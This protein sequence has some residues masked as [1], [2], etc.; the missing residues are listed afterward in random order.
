[1]KRCVFSS[2]LTILIGWFVLLLVIIEYFG[3]YTL[4][5]VF[6]FNKSDTCFTSI[7][8]WP[9]GSSFHFL[10]ISLEEQMFLI[11]IA[12]THFFLLW[13]VL[14]VLYLRNSY[15]TQD[16]KDFLLFSS[17]V[18]GVLGFTFKSIVNFHVSFVCEARYVFKF[19]VFTYECSI[20]SSTDC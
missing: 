16:Y 13:I 11:L 17:E 6:F 15:Q 7:F 9:T 1:M 10:T 20:F 8:F 18:L 2:I 14:L 19:S 5:S 4:Y 12:L 3:V